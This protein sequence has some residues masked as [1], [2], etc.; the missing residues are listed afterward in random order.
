MSSQ[1]ADISP[2]VKQLNVTVDGG[3]LTRE[4]DKAYAKLSG[5]AKIKGFRQGKIPRQVLERYYRRD[6][7]SDVLNRVISDEYRR[8]ILENKINP[9]GQPQIQAAEFIAGQDLQFT[10]KVE[11][12]PAITLTTYKG[13]TATR[14]VKPLGET[15]INAEI[16]RL[17]QSVS[18]IGPVTDRDVVKAGDLCT[19]NYYGTI[20]D[21]GFAGGSG[22]AYVI[23]Q[24][25]ARFF[26]EIE[27]ALVGKKVG[28]AFEVD[29]VIPDNFRNK[30][31]RGKTAHFKVTV[32]EL[33]QRNVPAL[34]D[35]FAKDLGDYESL[36]DLKDK[37]QK[38]LQV[39]N[40]ESVDNDIREQL[41]GQLIEK[42][43]FELPPSLVERQI[44]ARLYP[45]L[46]RMSP[47]QIKRMNVD[48]NQMREEQRE[49]AVRQIRGALLLEALSEQ[50]KL[51]V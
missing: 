14:D 17:R 12:K 10:A 15:E 20:D 7:E 29:A 49:I 5:T 6:V 30:D 38:S 44:D 43:A 42:N 2:V 13:L 19:T 32:T 48:R 28:D 23:E 35:E 1:V 27:D 37:T 39:R 45:I 18:T 40:Q 9:V 4:L 3:V 46:G 31:V 34:D 36:A 26:K 11:V 47:E 16:E 8:A 41:V 25:A 21:A 51:A 50:E 33:K 24:G 22:S